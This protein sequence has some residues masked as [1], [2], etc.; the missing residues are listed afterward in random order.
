MRLYATS[1]GQWFGTQTE[2]A[3]AVRELLDS[4]EIGAHWLLVD[5]PTDKPGLLA[6]LNV[7]TAAQIVSNIE[8]ASS[9]RMSYAEQALSFEDGFE[10]LPLPLKLHF[11]ALAM[12]AARDALTE[13][14]DSLVGE[15]G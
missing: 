13:V 9:D 7:F 8:P 15:S 3:R 6:Y 11:A 1:N 2:A 12:E 14:R 4:G 10:A 5:V